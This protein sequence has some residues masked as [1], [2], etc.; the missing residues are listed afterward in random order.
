VQAGRL[1]KYSPRESESIELDV[2]LVMQVELGC[3]PS[4]QWR[5]EPMRLLTTLFLLAILS[6]AAHAQSNLGNIII[7]PGIRLGGSSGAEAGYPWIGMEIGPTL[8]FGEGEPR[9]GLT[10]TPYVGLLVYPFF[11]ITFLSDATVSEG[12][13]YLKF[14]FMADGSELIDGS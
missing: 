11:S 4:T 14:P 7:S 3:Q 13:A 9:F 12:G 1:L 8:V 6:Y 2:V 5:S 10:A